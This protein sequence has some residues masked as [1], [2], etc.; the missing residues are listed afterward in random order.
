[1][2]YSILADN[3][4]EEFMRIPHLPP[5]EKPIEGM[6]RG[7]PVILHYLMR[8]EDGVQP[9][10]IS[11]AL[12]IST[13]RVAA[14]LNNL[15]KKGLIVRDKDPADKRRTLVCLT[16]TGR[17]TEKKLGR[18]VKGSLTEVLESLGEEDAT[19]FVRIVE[20]ILKSMREKCSHHC[21]E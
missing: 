9:I 10:E 12:G 2:D 11:E 15:E 16:Q 6:H 3:L 1:M 17:D 14:A 13:A 8:Y 18:F 19:E 21:G 5:K 4:F 7:M 20:R